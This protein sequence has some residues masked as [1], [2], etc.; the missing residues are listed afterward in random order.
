M[1]IWFEMRSASFV[2]LAL[3]QRDKLT[4]TV[5]M[6]IITFQAFCSWCLEHICVHKMS[7]H[8]QGKRMKLLPSVSEDLSHLRGN[9]ATPQVGHS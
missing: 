5:Y 1:H 4:A 6:R 9:L 3:M 8:R 2:A 7:Y